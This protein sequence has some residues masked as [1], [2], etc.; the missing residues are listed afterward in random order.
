MT[1]VRKIHLSLKSSADGAP[2]LKNV[3][4]II[5]YQTFH[6]QFGKFTIEHPCYVTEEKGEWKL[7]LDFHSD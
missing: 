2:V 6:S 5:V 4:E 7:H 1:F 3:Y